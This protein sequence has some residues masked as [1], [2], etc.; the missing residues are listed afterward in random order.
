MRR[1]LR[2]RVDRWADARDVAEQLDHFVYRG[3]CNAQWPLE[4]S[5]ERAAK[6]FGMD[7]EL[8]ASQ[9]KFVLKRFIRRACYM[10]QASPRETDMFEWLALLQHHGGSSRLLDFTFSFAVASFFAM[11]TADDACAVWAVDESALHIALVKKYEKEIGGMFSGHELNDATAAIVDS[12]LQSQSENPFLAEADEEPDL[13]VVATPMRI[14]ERLAAQHGTFLVPLDLATPLEASLMA[15]LR[16]APDA[17]WEDC[18]AADVCKYDPSGIAIVK[19]VIPREACS[20]GLAL[21]ADANVTAATLF[22]GLDGFARSLNLIL[23]Q[24][25]LTRR[26]DGE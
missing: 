18:A 21:L 4:T 8:I 20:A 15:S 9:E 6:R 14:S 23:R 19:F 7:R 11:E 16:C 5:I 12:R 22:P 13:V 17:H 3:Q 26:H 10:S 1:L 2:V 24:A 25:E